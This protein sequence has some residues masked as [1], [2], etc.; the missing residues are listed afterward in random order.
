MSVRKRDN[1]VARPAVLER[2]RQEIQEKKKLLKDME[3][4]HRG[5]PDDVKRQIRKQELYLQFYS[6]PKL[7][8]RQKDVLAREKKELEDEIVQ[9]TNSDNDAFSTDPAIMQKAIQKEV[10]RIDNAKKIEKLKNINNI[11]DPDPNRVGIEY[12]KNRVRR[13]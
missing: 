12:L 9:Y 4:Y 13:Y 10:W 11:L 3:D 5:D 2:I 1:R 6:P 8:G 7:S